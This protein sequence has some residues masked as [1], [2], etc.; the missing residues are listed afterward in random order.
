M[1]IPFLGLFLMTF[2][3]INAQTDYLNFEQFSSKLQLIAKEHSLAH[4]ESIG[5]S[6]SGKDIW[7]LHLGERKS[8]KPAL[9]VVANLDGVHQAGAQISVLMIEKWMKNADM[10]RYLESHHIYFIPVVSPDAMLNIKQKLQYEKRGNSKTTDDDRNGRTGDDPYDDLNNDGFIT[11]M[12]IESPRGTY[13]EWEQ[14]S[15]VLVPAQA[16]KGQIG[17]YLLL[18]EGIDNNKNGIFNE[19]A[20]EG[21]NIDQNFAYNYPIFEKGSGIYAVSESETKALMD[22]V[23]THPEIYGIFTFGPRN[24]V[25]EPAKFDKKATS[26]RII[27]DLL[28]QDVKSQNL[29]QDL[30][31]NKSKLKDGNMTPFQ[32][33]SFTQTAYFHAGKMSLTS[34]G[35]WLPK[36][37]K[38]KDSVQ[39]SPQKIKKVKDD[40]VP[41]LAKFLEWSDLQK[42]EVFIPWKAI[43]HPDFPNQKVEIGGIKPY[44]IQNPPV[45]YLDSVAEKHLVFMTEWLKAMPK[46]VITNQKTEKIDTDLFRITCTVVNKGLLPTYTSIADKIRFTSRFKTTLVLQNN[47]KRM[48]GKK[49]DLQNALQPDEERT[50]SWLVSGKGKVSVQVGCATSGFQEILF[51]LK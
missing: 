38:T 28:E 49:I 48:S 17:K 24:N 29:L 27:R 12:R 50:Y 20:S 7:M 36:I 15:R 14:D 23:Y 35:W 41:A 4:L 37:E 8:I 10:K 26:E 3:A 42:E 45:K 51:D 1:K 43:N 13:I 2:V 46:V 32:G 30:Y 11:Q 25:A 21:V 44:V 16:S 5:K 6:A 40:D 39:K 19:D 34:P 33:G 22:F 9:L 47:Q 18:T 31:A